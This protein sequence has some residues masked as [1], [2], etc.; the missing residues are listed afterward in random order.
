MQISVRSINNT[1]TYRGGPTPESQ[2]T[3]FRTGDWTHYHKGK[4]MS[5]E[6]LFFPPHI[7]SLSVEDIPVEQI[8]R[9]NSVYTIIQYGDYAA[10]GSQ[11]F[12]GL[13]QPLSFFAFNIVFA[14]LV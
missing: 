12:D 9:I 10:V 3:L 2:Q 11:E 5:N 4:N 1:I 6:S 7:D 8:F 14:L 13:L